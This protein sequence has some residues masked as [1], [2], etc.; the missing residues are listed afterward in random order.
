M[1]EVG[2][3]LGYRLFHGAVTM[4]VV[5]VA[6]CVI[7]SS[8]LLTRRRRRRLSVS[9]VT[10][11]ELSDFGNILMVELSLTDSHLA[12]TTDSVLLADRRAAFG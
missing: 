9:K 2:V 8:C 12:D 3:F 10:H 5:L 4:F 6:W 11:M 1:M 7:L